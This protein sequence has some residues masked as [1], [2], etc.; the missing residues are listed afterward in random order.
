MFSIRAVQSG[1]K[2]ENWDNQ[3]S[4]ELSSA[5]KAEKMVLWIQLVVGL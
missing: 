1:Y 2:E 3:F 4:L 5:R